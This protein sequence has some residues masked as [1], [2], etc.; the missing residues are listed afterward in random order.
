[1]LQG[2]TLPIDT[3]DRNSAINKRILE[4]NRI[5]SSDSRPEWPECFRETRSRLIFP[6]PFHFQ[7]DFLLFNLLSKRIN[8]IR[9]AN[10][11]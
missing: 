7:F 8:N 3:R 4:E 10:A 11:N 9:T 1:M 5:E 2:N 6:L